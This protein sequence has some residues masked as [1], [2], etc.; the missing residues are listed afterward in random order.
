MRQN[1]IQFSELLLQNDSIR[2]EVNI[3]IYTTQNTEH[4]Y[5]LHLQYYVTTVLLEKKLFILQQILHS[6]TTYNYM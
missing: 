4:I 1:I 3:F 5:L 6:T 2:I